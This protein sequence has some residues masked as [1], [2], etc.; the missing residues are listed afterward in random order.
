MAAKVE[1][2]TVFQGGI[3]TVR[4][5]GDRVHRPA[6]AAAPAV[7]RL[8]RHLRAAGFDGAPEPLGYDDEGNEVLSFLEGDVHTPLP[9]ELRTP[10]LLTSAAALL[11]RFHDASAT[12]VPWPD[13]RWQ[14][15]AR[16]PAEVICHGDIAPYNSVVRDGRVVGF[17]DFDVAHP[18]P[19]LWD[20]AYAVYRFA[21]LH[22]P[23]NPDS[24]G[25]PEEQARR[26][27]HFCRAYGLEPG[28]ALL[29]AV[30]DRLAALLASM[31]ARAEAGEAASLAH[32]AA[33]HPALYEEDIR[34][35]RAQRDLLLRVFAA[36]PVD[37]G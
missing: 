3:N 25:S 12:F 27:A 15:P 16:S 11:R 4:R 13:D 36:P 19:R 28:A 31:R 23:T 37:P 34:Y 22:A 17:F 7:H 5:R 33:G 1:E 18:G 8:L 6:S 30:A 24:D 14:L 21:P 20:L 35:L 9:A 29:D 32:I 10:D 2:E 26:A